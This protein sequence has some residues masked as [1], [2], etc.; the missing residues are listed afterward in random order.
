MQAN[1]CMCLKSLFEMLDL[2]I[3]KPNKLCYAVCE[4]S[5][6]LYIGLSC[7]LDHLEI[8]KMP[9][10]Q[11]TVQLG[12]T[13]SLCCCLVVLSLRRPVTVE[14]LVRTNTKILCFY[15]PSH[16]FLFRSEINVH[17]KLCIFLVTSIVQRSCPITKSK[18][19]LQIQIE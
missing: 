3:T 11:L 14:K 8:I 4:F 9:F 12:Y 15:P 6:I 13:V 7:L 17:S 1:F 18:K 10:L 19:E 16:L 2:L 5:F